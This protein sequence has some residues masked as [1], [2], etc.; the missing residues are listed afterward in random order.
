M[1]SLAGRREAVGFV[2]ARHGLPE[3]RACRLVGLNRASRRYARRRDDGELR[4]RLRALALARPRYGYRRLHRVLRRSGEAV[5][6]KRVLRLYRAEGR[7]LRRK[8][9]RRAVA[10][11]RAAPTQ[12]NERWAMDFMADGLAGGRKLRLL[13]V[14][15][16]YT[17]ECLAI[18]VDRSLSAKRVKA[19]LERLAKERGLPAGLVSDNGPEFRAHALTLWAL[20]RGLK[21]DFIAPGKPVE[22][23]FIESFNGRVR[24]E[25]LNQHRFM[26]LAEARVLIEAWRQDYNRRRPHSALGGL[27]PLEFRQRGE[28]LRAHKGAAPRPV[29]EQPGLAGVS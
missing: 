13:T 1:V 2:M 21:Q 17:R 25:C 15:D 23:A 14:L 9:V 10:G 28:A 19:V 11:R 29:A 27:T 24:D 18:A 12:P 4:V 20:G 6:V 5:N 8:R 22:N 3:R 16:E 26:S 7:A